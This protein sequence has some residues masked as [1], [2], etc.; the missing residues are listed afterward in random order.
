[1]VKNP[2]CIF[3]KYKIGGEFV[4]KYFIIGLLA[5]SILFL[6]GC[7]LINTIELEEYQ[8]YLEDKYGKDKGFYMVRESMCNWFELGE[9]TYLFSSNEL[10]EKHL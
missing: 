7:S 3:N 1:M 8:T 2:I 5:L 6:N 10:M 4:K 9:C